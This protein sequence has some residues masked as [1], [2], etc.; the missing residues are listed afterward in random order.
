[1]PGDE[2]QRVEVDVQALEA[3]EGG[4]SVPLV[5]P[6]AFDDEPSGQGVEMY[7]LHADR[8]LGGGVDPGDQQVVNERGP[9]RHER[10][11]HDREYRSRE[12]GTPFDHHESGPDR[13]MRG[14]PTRSYASDVPPGSS[15]I[16]ALN[17]RFAPG[18]HAEPGI[19]TGYDV[20]APNDL[21]G[22][23][24]GRDAAAL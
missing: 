10:E 21:T 12:E 5:D 1:M 16:K 9:S 14:L 19:P 13:R 11:H 2:G 4:H 6:K 20:P 18:R 22:G 24:P 7:G 8:P 3:G 17:G 23:C 15:A